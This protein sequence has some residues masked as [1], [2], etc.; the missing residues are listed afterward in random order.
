MYAFENPL[1]ITTEK[2]WIEWIFALKSTA[3]KEKYALEIVEGWRSG[4]IVLLGAIPCIGSCL[5]GILWSIFGG[6]IQTAF[7]VA[8]FIITASGGRYKFQFIPLF[9]YPVHTWFLN[10]LCYGLFANKGK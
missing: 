8:S 3:D 6:D 4:R 7:A 5:T 9:C 10:T 2:Q 1:K